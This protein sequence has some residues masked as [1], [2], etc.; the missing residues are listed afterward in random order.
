MSFPGKPEALHAQAREIFAHALQASNVDAA[1]DKRLSF[2]G[3]RLTIRGEPSED[4]FVIQLL[5]YEKVQVVAVGKAALSMSGSL[6]SRLPE[7]LRIKGVCCSPENAPHP[8]PGVRYFTGGHP[9][10]NRASVQ[11][12]EAALH[13]LAQS[14]HNTFIF[15]LIS[16]GGSALFEK[17]LDPAIALE[18]TIAFHRAL[19]ASGAAIAEMNIVRKHYSAVKGG[20]LAAAAPEADQ[21]TL[22]ISDVAAGRLDSIASGP[23]MPDSSTIEECREILHRYGLLERFSKSVRE[24]FLN[25]DLPETPKLNASFA[26]SLEPNQSS[27]AAADAVPAAITKAKTPAISPEYPRSSPGARRSIV[28]LSNDDLLRAAADFARN[29]GWHVVID[30]TC[31][32]WDYRDAACYLFER[33]QQLSQTL[34]KDLRGAAGGH[35]DRLCLLSGGEVTVHLDRHPGSGGRNQQFA[36]A[37]ALELASP[38]NSALRCGDRPVTRIAVLSAGSDGVDG[39]SPAAG[40]IADDTTAARARAKGIDPDAALQSFDSF[41]LFNALADTIVTGPTKNNL[42]DLRMVLGVCGIP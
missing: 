10:P 37:F 27:D 31:D 9:L 22:L 6:F 29:A 13:L 24:F 12:A 35:L 5:R 38:R 39:D 16:G 20:R 32:D 17:P 21:V 1:F 41:P 15:F 28:L 4:D 25:P 33:F 36:L 26:P 3:G 8:Y 34:S 42:R 7:G 30:N 14:D 2:E 11:A 18:D 40:A 19:L 23:T